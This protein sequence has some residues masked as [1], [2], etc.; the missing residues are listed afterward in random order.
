LLMYSVSAAIVLI[1]VIGI[2]VFWRARTQNTDE[3][4]GAVPAAS[5][6][7]ESA[8]AE[9]QVPELAETA[10]PSA[11][12][13]EAPAEPAVEERETAPSTSMRAVKPRN[14]KRN[15]NSRSSAPAMIPGQ[16][17]VD[18][19]PQGAQ[20]QV[21]GHGD[22]AWVTPYTVSTLAPGQHTVVISKA[23]FGQ[24]TRTADLSSANRTSLVVH[25]A[26]L[27]GT[28]VVGSDPPGA[29]IYLDGKDTL[30]LTPSQVTLE[31]G[32][33]TILV[34]KPGFLDETTSATA[35]PGQTSHFSPTLRPLGNADDIKTVGKFK[36][37]FGKGNGQTGMVKVSVR[38]TPKGA[39]IAVNRR[40]L[41]KV[42]PTEFLVNPGS[43][44]VDITLTGYKPVQ[45]VIS[46][47]QGGNVTIDE[48]LQAD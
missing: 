26:P 2:A 35:Q 44:I 9:A 7:E 30:R 46:V 47:D 48:T 41:E 20:I 38:T 3:D 28:V 29:S 36:K 17:M 18:S 5:A 6:P 12:P 19:T 13:A 1:L 24:A 15:R 37:L 4:G 43:Y 8:P 34:R 25:L 22:P 32:T 42:S 45:K 33:H 40:M 11:L 23:G 14:G 10:P 16:L 27:T 39:Q 31:K 21:D